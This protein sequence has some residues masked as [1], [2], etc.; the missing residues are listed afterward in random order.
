MKRRGA[1]SA[2]RLWFRGVRGWIFF[3]SVGMMADGD[4]GVNEPFRVE[5]I[6]DQT[7]KHT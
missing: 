2:V 3:L 4:R 6:F 1:P 5:I 7:L